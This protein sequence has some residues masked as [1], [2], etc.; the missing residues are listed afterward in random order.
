MERLTAEVDG[1]RE[2]R[3][4]HN[5]EVIT[6]SVKAAKSEI[7]ENF[8]A[9][10]YALCAMRYQSAIVTLWTNSSERVNI[11]AMKRGPA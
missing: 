7:S 11:P 6:L 1:I 3:K 4:E 9:M 8:N 5:V 2:K 10:R